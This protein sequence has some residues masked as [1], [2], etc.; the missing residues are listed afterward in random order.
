MEIDRNEDGNREKGQSEGQIWQQRD[1][2][3]RDGNSEFRI[4]R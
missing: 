4:E 3:Y 1:G 2:N